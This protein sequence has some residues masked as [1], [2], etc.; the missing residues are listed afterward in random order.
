MGRDNTQKHEGLDGNIGLIE[1]D[2]IE[3]ITNKRLKGGDGTDS[4]TKVR[5]YEKWL[6]EYREAIQVKLK[7]IELRT[8]VIRFTRH[9]IQKSRIISVVYLNDANNLLNSLF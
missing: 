7:S 9:N 8:I 5:E 2:F 6:D 1:K 4:L 3:K